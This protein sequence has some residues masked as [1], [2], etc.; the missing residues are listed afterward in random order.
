[1]HILASF[2]LLLIVLGLSGGAWF[3]WDRAGDAVIPAGRYLGEAGALSVVIA[4]AMSMIRQR[5]LLELRDF[6]DPRAWSV[7]LVIIVVSDWI[8]RP[9]GLFEGPT[10]RGEIIVGSLAMF[11]LLHR[12]W[13]CF[14]LYWPLASA[15]LILWSFTIAS[16]GL[17]LFSDDH[18]MFLFRLKL[19]KENFPSIPFWSPLWNAGFDA[20][21][22]FATGALNAFL[23]GAPLI[24]LF[25]VESVY[26]I[27]VAGILW[28][29][30]P[31]SV[32]AGA[33]LIGVS[34]IGASVA[35]TLSLCSGL[36]WY[37]WSLKYGTVGFIV[38]GTL[39]PLVIGLGLRFIEYRRPHKRLC[40]SLVLTTSLMLLWSPSGVALLPLGLCAL[41]KLRHMLLSRRHILTVVLIAVIN[42]PWMTMMWKVSNVGKFLDA[43]K[44]T[45]LATQEAP[46]TTADSGTGDMATKANRSA[47]ETFRHRSGA[48]DAK[49]S[50]NQ[51]HN[52]ASALNPLLVVFALP[53]LL[54]LTGLPRM[55]LGLL[56]MWLMLLGTVGVSLK[57]QLELDR[58]V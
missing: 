19:L 35:A 54:S 22:F 6:T 50:L 23:L 30:L 47:G 17:L 41:P 52:N 49:K 57:P 16:N 14:L 55:A 43:D 53:A 45:H 18:A 36:F 24:Y 28:V 58:M 10:I 38:S 3:L 7:G 4:Y 11:A 31:A 20:R 9:W 40:L 26:N 32:F 39:F 13:G 8:C 56:T 5:R 29:L 37:R 25:P 34:R 44:G 21:D 33:A 48:I 15:A 12:W 2:G 27:L 42:I 1:M 51:W 46:P